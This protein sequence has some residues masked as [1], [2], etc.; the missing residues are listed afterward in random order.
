MI[1]WADV[2]NLAK[3]NHLDLI[4][5]SLATLGVI[6]FSIQKCVDLRQL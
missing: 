2:D 6:T 1:A 4:S 3:G 5:L